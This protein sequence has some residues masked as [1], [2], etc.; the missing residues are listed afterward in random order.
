MNL[1]AATCG[2]RV[3]VARRASSPA[4][5]AR[6]TARSSR[7]AP[8]A[9]LD[10]GR[11]CSAVELV[12]DLGDSAIV[13]FSA[14]E[15]SSRC[16]PTAPALREGERQLAFDPAAVHR[17]DTDGV[18]ARLRARARGTSVDPREADLAP[19]CTA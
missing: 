9:S 4:C 7:R 2:G 17:F 10:R 6:R 14:G 12:E 3:H 13:D 8:R 5:T 18:R 15:R 19:Q 11:A 1:L 16:A